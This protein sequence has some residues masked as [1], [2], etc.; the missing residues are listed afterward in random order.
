M[1][2]IIL[3]LSLMCTVLLSEESEQTYKYTLITKDNS[4]IPIKAYTDNGDVMLI[5]KDGMIWENYPTNNINLITDI[6][7]EIIWNSANR[8]KTGIAFKN[9]GMG[10]EFH[11]M[12]QYQL[13]Y[14]ISDISGYGIYLPLEIGSFTIEPY[15]VDIDRQLLSNMQQVLLQVVPHQVNR[16]RLN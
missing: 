5:S 14:D 13:Y 1:K 7:G 4:S 8:K 11:A 9:Y 6:D 10:F 2:N 15:I 3:I 12:P 16:S